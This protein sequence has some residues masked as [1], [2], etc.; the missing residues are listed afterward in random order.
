LAVSVRWNASSHAGA[1]I[2]L[3]VVQQEMLAGK[4]AEWVMEGQCASKERKE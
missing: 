3:L 4:H 2:A 1:V